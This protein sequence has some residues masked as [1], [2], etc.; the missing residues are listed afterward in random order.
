MDIKYLMENICFKATHIQ[1][2]KIRDLRLISW[3]DYDDVVIIRAQGSLLVN[4]IQV[5][6]IVNILLRE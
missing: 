5:F 2:N 3:D 6:F 4:L 1:T